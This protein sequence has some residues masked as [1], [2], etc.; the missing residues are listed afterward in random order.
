[1][2]VDLSARVPQ[3]VPIGAS[4]IDGSVRITSPAAEASASTVNGNIEIVTSGAANAET[5][6]GNVAIRLAK[7]ADA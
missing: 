1:M 4:T 7:D 5:V 2:C 6:N 3:G